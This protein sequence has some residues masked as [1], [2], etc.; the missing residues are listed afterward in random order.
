MVA[1]IVAF[2]W[3]FHYEVMYGAIIAFKNLMPIKGIMGSPWVGLRHFESFF[4]SVYFVRILRNTLM[5][6][7]KNLLFGFP[8]PILLA[9]LINEIRSTVFK[10]TVQTF[11]YLPYFISTMV[12]SGIIKD[13]CSVN[14]VITE[15]CRGLGMKT[16][17]SMLLVSRYFQPIYIISDIWRGMGWNSII[18]LAALSGIDQELYE[19]AKIDGAGRLRQTLHITLPG[20]SSTI[21]VLLILRVGQVMNVGFEKIILLYSPNIYDVSDVI[22]SF[23]YR[24]GILEQNYSYGAAV[25]LFNSSINFSLLMATNWF[26]KRVSGGEHSL[27]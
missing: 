1:P 17:T 12:I 13:F 19:A 16:Q 3:I 6:S 26:S 10:R 18:Y 21:V 4:S 7:L 11:S 8:A 22:S 15:I 5:I 20:I 23:V 25:G 24:K 9:L 2:Y 27:F 14:G